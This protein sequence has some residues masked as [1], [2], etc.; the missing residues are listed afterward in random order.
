MKFSNNWFSPHRATWEQTV[1]PY[2]PRRILEIGSFE[3]QSI[4]FLI[5]LL[6]KQA[7]LEIYCVDT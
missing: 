4:C 6:G 2:Q 5:E 1:P 3:G 7:E